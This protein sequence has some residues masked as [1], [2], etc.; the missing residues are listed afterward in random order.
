MPINARIISWNA[1]GI[2]SHLD[3]LLYYLKNEPFLPDFICVQET[4]IY[5][6][7]LPDIKGYNYVHTF[8]SNRK[9]GGSAIYVKHKIDFSEINTILFDDIEIE[10]SG[11]IFKRNKND[12]ITL[13]SVYIAPDQIINPLHLNKLIVDK[14]LIM[15]GDF[16]AKHTLW[17]SPKNDY[18]GIISN[19]LEEKNLV[20]I[21]KG[22]G[23]RLNVNGSLS[24]LDLVFTSN[25]LSIHSDCVRLNELWGSDHYPLLVCCDFSV[26]KIEC[27]TKSYNYKKAN[28]QQYQDSLNNDFNLEL[29]IVDVE[30]GYTKFVQ[31]LFEARN[32]SIPL[33]SEV[34]KHKYS[35]YWNPQCSGAKIQKKQAEKKLRKSNSLGNQILFKRSKSNFKLILEKVKKEYWENYCKGLNR[36]TKLGMVWESISKLKGKNK[37]SEIKIKDLNGK[38]I[39]DQVSNNF[40]TNFRQLCSDAVIDKET[41]SYRNLVIQEYVRSLNEPIRDLSN[42]TIKNDVDLIKQHF[43]LY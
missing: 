33:Y 24:H 42:S 15:V 6:D 10:V 8:R 35:P 27:K 20:C 14:N 4:K 43:K 36:Q 38:L 30:T 34:R 19:F 17:G 16:N 39:E 21:N 9:G 5:Q 11:I 18:R 25:N 12:Y 3:E 37:K 41:L 31:A 13:L 7:K 23:T 22:F 2:G 40:A 29:P 1:N 32:E 28:W 26:D